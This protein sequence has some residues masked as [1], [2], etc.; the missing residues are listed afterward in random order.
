[1]PKIEQLA[2]KADELQ[3]PVKQTNDA[4]SGALKQRSTVS[5]LAST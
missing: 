2:L 5:V 4:N 3:Q 1:M